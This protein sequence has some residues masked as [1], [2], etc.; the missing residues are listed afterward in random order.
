MV[1]LPDKKMAEHCLVLIV[2]LLCFATTC[3]GANAT[4]PCWSHRIV[5]AAPM[6]ETEQ[7]IAV[8]VR[9]VS[10]WLKSEVRGVMY[11]FDIGLALNT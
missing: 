11:P 1:H 7:G 10:C 4:N 8:R 9:M 2:T 6:Y 3:T 5:K